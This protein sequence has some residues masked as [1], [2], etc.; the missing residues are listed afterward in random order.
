[1]PRLSNQFDAA[2]PVAQWL[3]DIVSRTR[4]MP[5]TAL[6]PTGSAGHSRA[7]LARP[8][9]LGVG[10]RSDGCA[11]LRHFDAPGGDSRQDHASDDYLSGRATHQDRRL[12]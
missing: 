5:I 11:P 1:M 4:T 8:R 7:R 2:P 6:S 3:R 12:A 9:A 10:V